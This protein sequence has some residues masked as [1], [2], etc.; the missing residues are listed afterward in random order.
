M[1]SAD[2][3]E[4]VVRVA[5]ESELGCMED[6]DG[7]SFSNELGGVRYGRATTFDLLGYSAP[8]PTR[9][10]TEGIEI[11]VPA[12]FL[13]RA[14]YPLVVDPIILPFSINPPDLVATYPDIAYDESRQVYGVVLKIGLDGYIV[15]YKAT[16][17]L[18]SKLKK[19]GNKN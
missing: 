12:D 15:D 19:K 14:E 16:K 2:H 17:E 6:A 4:L 1:T 9:R 7:F 3:G 10:T 8:S 11:R 18:R 5:V 13:T